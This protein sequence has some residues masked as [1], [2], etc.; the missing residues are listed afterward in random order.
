MSCALMRM[1]AAYCAACTV[2]DEIVVDWLLA[3]RSPHLLI[4]AWR[5]ESR[6]IDLEG[7][8]IGIRALSPLDLAGIFQRSC[9][10]LREI[11]TGSL[12]SSTLGEAGIVKLH[13]VLSGRSPRAAVPGAAC[14]A[15]GEQLE[16]SFGEE[17]RAHGSLKPRLPIS[18]EAVS[19]PSSMT[20]LM[21]M[22]FAAHQFH[23]VFG[24]CVCPADAGPPHVPSHSIVNADYGGTALGLRPIPRSYRSA[25]DRGTARDLRP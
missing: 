25:R 8:S 24:G 20:E 6:R 13:D 9:V 14:V 19:C 2:V 23:T 7:W 5:S 3:Q 16:Q 1:V 22:L 4:R 17:S 15:V 18:L 10:S 11:L 12:P 21:N